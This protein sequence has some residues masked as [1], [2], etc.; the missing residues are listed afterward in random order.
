MR[1]ILIALAGGL[2]VAGGFVLTSAGRAPEGAS[3]APSWPDFHGP[4]RSNISPEKG[5]LKEWPEGGPPLAWKYTGLGKG[6][7][8]VNVAEGLIF[9]AGDFDDT[10][11]VIALSLDGK[12]LWKSPNGEAWHRPSGGARTTPTYA[13]GAVF[14]MSPHGRIAAFDAQ[15]GKEIWAVELKERFQAEHGIWGFAENLIVEGDKVLCMPGGVKGRVVALD[16]RSGATVWANTDI[17]QPAA[18]CSPVVV[19]HQGVRQ[20]LSMTQK[21][22]VSLDLATG[23]LV[24]SHP[25]IPKSPQNATTPVFHDGYVFV[26]GGHYKGGA[27]LKVDASQRNVQELWLNPDLDNCHGGVILVDGKLYGCG[28][29]M[30]GKL[31]FCADFLTGQ[32]KQSDKTLSKVAITSADGMIYCLNHRGRMSLLEITPAGFRIVSHFDLEKK[33]DNSY[34][35]HPV[36]CGGRLYL[37]YAEHLYAYEVRAPGT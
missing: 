12:L 14:Q 3:G 31:F 10:E 6:Y 29:R 24:W 20:L 26:A 35:G 22:V 21:S 23:R 18:Y 8:G 28:C 5:L 16:R 32:I 9:T 15:R 17:D 27:L 2:A 11:M 13:A 1:L 19:E 25:F 34:L 7:S 33:P 36:V 4:G 37:R 30:G